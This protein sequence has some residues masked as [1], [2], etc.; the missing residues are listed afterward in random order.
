MAGERLA[1]AARPED[2]ANDERFVPLEQNAARAI[3]SM[4]LRIQDT[5][6]EDHKKLKKGVEKQEFIM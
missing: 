3:P 1:K 5:N 4:I 2:L 6:L